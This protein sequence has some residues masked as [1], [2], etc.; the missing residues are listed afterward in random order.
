MKIGQ[1][2]AGTPQRQGTLHGEA[3]KATL[4]CMAPPRCKKAKRRNLE[5]E[6]QA[7]INFLLGVEFGIKEGEK[8]H[9]I[10]MALSEAQKVLN[11][12]AAANGK[13]GK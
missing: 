10:Q 1:R 4:G 2:M 3:H 11:P 5:A 6:R 7:R 8:G 12:P 9:N 13:R